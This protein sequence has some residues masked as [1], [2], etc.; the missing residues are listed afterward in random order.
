MNKLELRTLRVHFG[1]DRS[2]LQGRRGQLQC[3]LFEQ[4]CEI[5]HVL[6]RRREYGL[7]LGRTKLH[8]GRLAADLLH[9]LAMWVLSAFLV[10]LLLESA[11]KGKSNS[12]IDDGGMVTHLDGGV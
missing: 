12:G 1:L 9:D 3:E 4:V 8:Q 7:T 5:G 2:L 6:E 10:N 11:E